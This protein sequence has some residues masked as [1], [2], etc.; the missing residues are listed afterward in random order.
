MTGE[1]LER[2]AEYF[3]DPALFWGAPLVLVA[4]RAAILGLLRLIRRRR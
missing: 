4:V 2:F 3:Y 1:M